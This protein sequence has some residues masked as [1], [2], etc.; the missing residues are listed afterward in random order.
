MLNAWRFGSATPR[1]EPTLRT[2]YGEMEG[3][4]PR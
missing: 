4:A 1:S 2:D 3:D